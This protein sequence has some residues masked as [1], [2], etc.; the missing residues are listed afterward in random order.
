M[1]W[2]LVG[3]LILVLLPVFVTAHPI[4]KCDFDNTFNCEYGQTPV[5]SSGVTFVDGKNGKGVLINESDVLSYPM[6]DG[7]KNNWGIA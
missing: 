2:I 5:K 3:F 1:K 6:P 4:L 7:F